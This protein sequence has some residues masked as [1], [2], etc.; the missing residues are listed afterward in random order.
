MRIDPEQLA[1]LRCKKKATALDQEM[2]EQ[3]W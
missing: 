1:P 3:H 2:A